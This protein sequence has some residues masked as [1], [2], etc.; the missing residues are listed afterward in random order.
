MRKENRVG[1]RRI[2]KCGEE[3]EI[4]EYK[5]NR[6]V[7]VK[8][9]NTGELVK[10]EYKDFK[11]G[12][13]KSHFTPSVFGIGVVGLENTSDKEGKLLK[14]YNTWK[15]ILERCYDE[16]YQEKNPRYIGCTVC[17]EWLYYPN[18]K[19]W[20]D[21]NYYEVDNQRIALD[22][23]ILNKNNK[24]YSPNNCVFVPQNINTLFVKC[25]TKR[26]E[27]PVGVSWKEKNKKHQAQCQIFD[28]EDNKSKGKYLGLYNTPEEAFQAYKQ[29]KEENIKQV[30]NFYKTQIPSQLYN[31]MINYKVEIT[32]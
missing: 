10:G 16:K 17:D 4:I 14:S 31:A 12:F 19:K 26:G 11:N 3:C 13:I 5:N 20:Y 30:A 21:E 28:I 8:F 25:N 1:E 2:M 22:K 15:G 29:F 32:D 24:V 6:N 23:D 9:L 27:Y 7:L 18:F